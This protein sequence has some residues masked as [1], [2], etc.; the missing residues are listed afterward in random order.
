M[1]ELGELR[2]FIAAAEERSFSKAAT[3][4]N[5]S[6]SAVSQNIQALEKSF[7]VELFIR[8]GRSVWL[9][10]AGQA[11]L[12]L[13]RDVMG[14]SRLME[15]AMNNIQG[16]VAG[17][18]SIGC[19]TTSG[20]YLL[21]NLV[22]SF[23]REYPLVHVQINILTREEV[24]DRIMDGR[25]SLGVVSKRIDH[26]DIEHQPL[27]EDQVI[28]IVPP[29]HCWG[30]YGKALP[31]DL[32][33]QPL[34]MREDNAGSSEVLYEGLAKHGIIPSMLNPV[35]EIGNSE[36]IEMAVE[37]GI[38]IAFVSELAAARGLALGRVKKVDV[39]G[40]ELHRTIYITR[41]IQYPLSRAQDRFWAFTMEQRQ[42]L[43][44]QIW[45]KIANL[46][47]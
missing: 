25:L 43:S 13:A 37:E 17:Q 31:A 15:E 32:I 39:E 30:T 22:A 26:H 33:D 34:I 36:A 2:V 23:R 35:L 1:I 42:V 41:N 12:P 9:S 19:S 28:L 24:V 47:K 27:F 11:L 21:P 16:Q 6:Q 40:L 5:L 3:R 4:L 7:G 14:T 10:E 29:D 18:L 20:K 45:N 44:T 8:H 46:I 38:G